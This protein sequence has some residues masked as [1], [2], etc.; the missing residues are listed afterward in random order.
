MTGS[1]VIA[2]WLAVDF[3]WLELGRQAGRKG[4]QT[5]GYGTGKQG[6]AALFLL[7]YRFLWRRRSA[8]ETCVWLFDSGMDGCSSSQ[9]NKGDK[10]DKGSKRRRDESPDFGKAR[11]A[12]FLGSAVDD[13]IGRAR[14]AGYDG[15]GW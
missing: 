12:S 8:K 7:G 14:F 1:I 3:G 4:R 11:L 10:D 15:I 13:E 5:R 6:R 2:R 9:G